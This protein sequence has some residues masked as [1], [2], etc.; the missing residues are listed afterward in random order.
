L[1]NSNQ[2]PRAK[3]PAGLSTPSNSEA[4]NALWRIDQWFPELDPQVGQQLKKYYD[5]LLRFN[6]TVN[7][8][9]VKTIIVADAIHFADSI[10]SS[11]LIAKAGPIPEIY[12]FGSGNGFPGLVYAVLH[13]ATK[14]HL[15]EADGRKA[16]F[17]KHV[18]AH[19]ALKNVTVLIRTV[20][21]LPEKSV[22]VAISRGFAPIAKALLLSRRLFPRGGVYYHLKSEEWSSEVG[23]IPTQLCSF[24]TPSLVGEYRLP[25]GEVQFAVVRTDKIGD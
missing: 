18:A 1:D 21:S 20:E 15:V 2:N 24:W 4:T 6:R 7:L 11:R 3:K 8:I 19:L 16:E 13:P 22:K 23:Q 9:G 14:V 25:V 17:L 10:L 5:E 12:D